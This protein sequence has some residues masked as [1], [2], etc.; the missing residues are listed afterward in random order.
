MREA[1]GRTVS[2]KLPSSPTGGDLLWDDTLGLGPEIY[3]HP[4]F[5]PEQV[6]VSYH[7]SRSVAGAVPAT[8]LA[9]HLRSDPAGAEATGR[10]AIL[11]H[12]KARITL[13]RARDLAPPKG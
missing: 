6:T 3:D 8:A 9:I 10:A 11:P 12:A 2:F 13:L 4:R 1:Q 5:A 7:A